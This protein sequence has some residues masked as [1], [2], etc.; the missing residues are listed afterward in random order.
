MCKGILQRVLRALALLACLMIT[1]TDDAFGGPIHEAAKKGDQDAVKALIEQNPALINDRDETGRTPLHWA[2]RGVHFQV[3]KL[4]LEKGAD[5]N[6]K[7]K[8]LTTAIHELATRN[9][10]EGI[11]LLLARGADIDARDYGARTAL[12]NAA[13]N[14]AVEATALLVVKGARLEIQDSYG[15]TPLL[16]CARE[17]GGPQTTAILLKAGAQVNAKDKFGDT[18]LDLAAWRGKEEVINLLLAAGAEIPSQGPKAQRLFSEAA[19]NGLTRLFGALAKA[20]ARPDVR[21]FSNGTLLHAAA[22]GGSVGIVEILLGR[23]LDINQKDDFGWTPLHYAARDG[24]L[25]VVELL[26]G[27][28]AKIN[29]RTLMGQSPV[30]VA[31]EMKQEKVRDFLIARGADDKAP[32][33]PM[34]NGDYLGQKPPGDEP[35]LFARGIVSSIWGLHSSVAFAPDGNTAM[36]APMVTIPGKL[37]SEG[38][39]IMTERKNGRWTAPGW[40]PFTGDVDGDVPFFSPDGKRVYFISAKSLPGTPESRR[41]RIWF[42]D[43]SGDGWGEPQV[44][45]DA[46]ND[47]PHHWQISVDAGH[48]I[49][50]SS[51]IPEG[52]GGGDIYRSKR[53]NGR[54]QKPE[55]LGPAVN[56]SKGEGMPYISPDGSYLLFSRDYDLFISFCARDGAW[57]EARKLD[58]PINSPSIEICPI[59]SPDGKYLF[60]ISQKGGESHVWWVK[61][62]FIERMRNK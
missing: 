10:A 58:A 8:N 21:L 46:V 12:H 36:W 22:A 38:G 55:N 49:Y 40:A 56:T 19:A 25:A 27:K 11:Q 3:V 18:P 26:A 15:R 62:G 39:V 13:T 1:L 24:R 35:E 50:F 41:E 4:L 52:L 23:G 2:A 34:L 30:N 42:V 60:F 37:Y 16:L 28:G 53:I 33:F 61:A 57:K 44:V 20:G 32:E 59:I 17:R 7:D 48:T 51:S 5:V 29:A 9:H 47:Y 31:R 43:K 45:D 6:A 14:D 54:W